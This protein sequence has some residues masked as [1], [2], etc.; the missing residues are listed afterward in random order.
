MQIT[1]R[2]HTTILL[3]VM[4]VLTLFTR[5]VAVGQQTDWYPSPWGADDQRGAANRLSP[6][7]VLAAKDLITTGQVYQLGRV[8]EAG[9][10]VF[11]TRHFSLKIPYALGPLGENRTMAHEAIISGELGQVGTQFDG[12]G[13]IGI[14]DLFYNGLSRHDFATPDGLTMLG[15]ENV[16]PIVTRGVLIDVAA[17]KGVEMLDGGYEITRSD[18]VGALTQQGVSI[19]TADVVLIHTGWGSLWM[20]DNE[21]FNASEPG[22]GLEA[23]EFLIDEEIV[24][25]GA[26]TWATEVLPNPDPSLAFPVHQLLLTKSGIYNI[27]NVA[28]ELLAADAVCIWR[29]YE[30][31]CLRVAPLLLKGA[32]GSPGNPIAIR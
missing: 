32:A 1:R 21:R 5:G 25:V 29:V 6:G 13:H 28:T 11:G 10:P 19:S 26:D 27:E 9:I 4:G 14:G 30:F 15:V 3:M 2:R 24:M 22:I 20:V 17:Y 31:A 7:E 12:L 23:A 8:Y 16:G 18:L